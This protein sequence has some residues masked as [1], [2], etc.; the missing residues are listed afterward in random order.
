MSA[1]TLPFPT[2]GRYVLHNLRL[3]SGGARAASPAAFSLDQGGLR[4]AAALDPVDDAT[5]PVGDEERVLPVDRDGERM[6]EAVGEGARFSCL[7]VHADELAPM[8]VGVVLAPFGDEEVAVPERHPA[9]RG[10][11]LR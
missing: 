3:E 1:E 5:A 7:D 2:V 6:L 11:R 4:L 9:G 10:V 8:Q